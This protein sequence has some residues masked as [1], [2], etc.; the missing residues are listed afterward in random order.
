MVGGG[1]VAHLA[2]YTHSHLSISSLLP[3][4]PFLIAPI[5]SLRPM[6]GSDNG[7]K[8]S[9]LGLI[10]WEATQRQTRRFVGVSNS[11]HF[12]LGF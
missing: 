12:R 10:E 9:R 11:D 6:S 5:P 1:G 8:A 2:A 3:S 4:H 7:P